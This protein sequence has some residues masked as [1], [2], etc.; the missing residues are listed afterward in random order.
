M[1]AV[2]AAHCTRDRRHDELA[3]TSTSTLKF[4]STTQVHREPR[5]AMAR[6]GSSPLLTGSGAAQPA[7]GSGGSGLIRAGTGVQ[8]A[9]PG[10]GR[11]GSTGLELR[12]VQPSSKRT[13]T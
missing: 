5:G 7:G 6:A 3:W 1:V 10:D 12:D 4:D 2:V 11:T 9:L 13:I 8:F